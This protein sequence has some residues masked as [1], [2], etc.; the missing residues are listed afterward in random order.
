M[1]TLVVE[2]CADLE[3][4][5][6]KP[7]PF[8]VAA[9]PPVLA[10]YVREAS[11]SIGCDPSFVAMPLLAS[12]AVAIGNKR[13]VQLKKGWTEPAII[14]TAIVSDSGEHKSP[15]QSAALRFVEERQNR[16]RAGGIDITHAT[17]DATYAG[18]RDALAEQ[19]DASLL[20]KPDELSEFIRSLSR[21]GQM[22]QKKGQVMSWWQA[23]SLRTLRY[24]KIIHIP[25][26]AMSV[27]GGIQ[28]TSFRR[29]I[30]NERNME[31]GFCARL[32]L[33]WQP[34]RRPKPWSD[35]AA[36]AAAVKDVRAALERLFE[37]GTRKTEG[38]AF[39][40]PDV[41]KLHPNAKKLWVE[42]YNRH[43]AEG[44]ELDHDL[45]AAWSKLRAYAARLALIW[46]MAQWSD[47]DFDLSRTDLRISPF[48]MRHAIRL[49]EWFKGEARRI[50]QLFGETDQDSAR[51]DLMA[52]IKRNGGAI[53][54]RDLMR[55]SWRYKT[56]AAAEAALADLVRV[57]LASMQTVRSSSRGGRPTTLFILLSPVERRE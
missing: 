19:L 29:A 38:Q 5:K 56:V 49:T 25:R 39:Y 43:N 22:S 47:L 42:F 4:V 1:T 23:G 27:V 15:S 48:A 17:N 20:L 32:L 54:A 18:V 34:S 52:T 16:L 21:S 40:R 31:D 30:V 12:V 35:K 51:R 2:E 33:T 14:W 41:L 6:S 46:Q 37:M 13:V 50:Y 8:P 10:R 24:K 36:S 9:L 28:P 44:H 26:V 55:R 11:A 53:T 7:K 45:K 57:D 3:K